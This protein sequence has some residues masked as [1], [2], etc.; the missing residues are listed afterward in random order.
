MTTLNTPYGLLAFPHFFQP[1]PR[2]EGGEPV[3]SACIIFSPAQQQSAAFKAMQDECIRLAKDKFGDKV[4]LKSVRF[5]FRKAEE[6][7]QWGGFEDGHVFIN[8]W[9]KSK[10]GIVNSQRQDVLL[11]EEV[12]P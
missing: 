10:P 9:T 2:A 1:R 4:D 3:Y 7:A 12:W 5:P 8:P 11:P 6:K